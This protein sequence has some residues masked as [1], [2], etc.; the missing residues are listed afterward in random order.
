MGNIQGNY[1]RK[2]VNRRHKVS[3]LLLLLTIFNS[4][5]F[6]LKMIYLIFRYDR[7]SN[8]TFAYVGQNGQWETSDGNETFPFYCKKSP[9]YF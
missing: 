5:F 6:K 7:S 9:Y 8:E 1:V 4:E 2:L 3:I